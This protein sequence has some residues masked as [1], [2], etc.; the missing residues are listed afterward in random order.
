M[1]P[2]NLD[3]SKSGTPAYWLSADLFERAQKCADA[4][5]RDCLFSLPIEEIPTDDERIHNATFGDVLSLLG[6]HGVSLGATKKITE[7]FLLVRLLTRDDAREMSIE[8]DRFEKGASNDTLA[9]REIGFMFLYHDE[10]E[11]VRRTLQYLAKMLNVPDEFAGVM[12][13]YR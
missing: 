11:L 8:V 9:D 13:T 3:W 12:I 2:T 1:P 4:D 5:D 10:P 7:A 6:G